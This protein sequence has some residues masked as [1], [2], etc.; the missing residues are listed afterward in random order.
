MTITKQ[1]LINTIA[2]DAG[3]SQTAARAA[4]N[5][6]VRTVTRMDVKDT[7]T[8]RGFGTFRFRE[9]AARTSPISFDAHT[10]LV[11]KASPQTRR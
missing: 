4:L 5:S 7:L 2:E 6:L 9:R 8:L 3:I 11:F 1:D 10:A